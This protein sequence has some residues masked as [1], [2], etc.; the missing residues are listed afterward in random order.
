MRSRRRAVNPRRGGPRQDRSR[1]SM[2]TRFASPGELGRSFSGRSNGRSHSWRGTSSALTHEASSRFTPTSRLRPPVRHREAT[3]RNGAGTFQQARGDGGL[4]EPGDDTAND[5]PGR[6]PLRL[7]V[8]RGL[9]RPFG[10]PDRDQRSLE[11]VASSMGVLYNSGLDRYSFSVSISCGRC[12]AR[13]V[14]P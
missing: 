14:V 8:P 3:C 2:Q 1:S 9:G 6:P 5:G 11:R 4:P 10:D 12:A 7:L 13:G